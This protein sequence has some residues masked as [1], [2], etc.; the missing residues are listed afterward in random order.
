VPANGQTYGPVS[1]YSLGRC[2]PRQRLREN[3]WPVRNRNWQETLF[4]PVPGRPSI[5]FLTGY[6]ASGYEI[7]GEW[8]YNVPSAT[9]MQYL[10]SAIT[11]VL[12]KQALR[13]RLTPVN[14]ASAGSNL[15][16]YVGKRNT[17]PPLLTNTPTTDGQDILIDL[18]AS[19]LYSLFAEYDAGE[20][21][22]EV[23]EEGYPSPLATFIFFLDR[24][25][26]GG[27]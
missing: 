13:I 17:A 23:W 16:C 26:A 27:V 21:Y 11:P 25:M 22:C 8:G 9:S 19:D 5:T 12:T 18:S 4:P 15:T 2:Y 14:P 10:N 24:S 20:M 1:Y 6:W 3:P 7:T